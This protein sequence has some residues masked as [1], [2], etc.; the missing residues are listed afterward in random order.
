[1]RWIISKGILCGAILVSFWAVAQ[2]PVTDKGTKEEIVKVDKRLEVMDERLE[3]LLEL[4]EFL[5][6][7]LSMS[8]CS[9]SSD[10]M[11]VA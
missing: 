9:S 5:N 3:V 8:K 4:T 7:K 6:H 2:V 11:D 10:V 1:M